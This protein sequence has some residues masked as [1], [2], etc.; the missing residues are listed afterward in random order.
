MAPGLAVEDTMFESHVEIPIVL[1]A[2]PR[3]VSTAFDKMMRTRGDMKVITEPFGAAY[4]MGP[5][6]LSGRYAMTEP[7][8]TFDSVLQGVLNAG[9]TGPVFVK[10][11]VYQLGPLVKYEVLNKFQNTFLIRDPAWALCSLEKI[12]PDF[13]EDEAGY[14]KQYQAWSILKQHGHNPIVID[15]DD[16]RADPEYIV[17]AW[18]DAVGIPRRPDALEWEPG[19]PDE[20]LPWEE[21]MQ[22]VAKSTGFLPPESKEPPTPSDALAKKIAAYKPLYNELAAHKI[23]RERI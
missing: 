21:F 7:K 18:C 13:S 9:R 2:T 23:G 16:L 20:W 12:R 11:L 22:V 8:A 5:E 14:L 4:H 3:T 6:K 1:W 19:M 17:G 10:E 15:S